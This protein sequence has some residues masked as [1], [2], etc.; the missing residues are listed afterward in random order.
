MKN[1][2][3]KIIAILGVI[4]L[5]GFS[6][7]STAQAEVIFGISG[8]SYQSSVATDVQ[9]QL[10]SGLSAS[11]FRL[12]YITVDDQLT[13][14][15]FTNFVLYE[16]S[17]DVASPT[18]LPAGCTA[19]AVAMESGA[20][21]NMYSIAQTGV[22]RRLLT[23]DFY[24]YCNNYG[25]CS[26]SH[27]STATTPIPLTAT[28][29]YWLYFISSASKTSGTPA[30][31]FSVWGLQAT[32]HSSDGTPIEVQGT[33]GS[34]LSGIGSPYVYLA[35]ETLTGLDVGFYTPASSS[36][37]SSLSGA[38]SFCSGVASSSYA[39]GIPYG[40]CYIGGFLFI[41]AQSA[42][43]TFWA[44][45]QM[46]K[47][48]APWSYLI[49]FKEVWESATSSSQE[50]P[51]ISIPIEIFGASTSLSLVSSASWTYW[52]STSTLATLR[53]F[54]TVALYISFAFYLWRRGRHV[55]KSL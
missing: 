31:N 14:S 1:R 7:A 45:A 33:A 26:T 46:V 9:Y 37:Q 50:F 18:G 24:Q 29:F 12:A 44:N 47:E 23:V 8:S 20:G 5:G 43:D 51:A 55:L 22:G 36:S 35:D 32:L 39:F 38:R 28:K 42:L 40:L 48:V 54:T 11:S 27:V 34:P 15:Y 19:K 21:G 17:T 10:G 2:R 13:S 41:P 6:F 16:C 30:G 52:V 4:I 49:D 3:Q 25:S 53:G